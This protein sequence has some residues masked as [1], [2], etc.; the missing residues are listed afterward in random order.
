MVAADIGVTL[1]I[2]WFKCAR[3]AALV[4]DFLTAVRRC[5]FP[6]VER[7]KL[8]YDKT[9]SAKRIHILEKNWRLKIA[10]RSR[11]ILVVTPAI[12][13]FACNAPVTINRTVATLSQSQLSSFQPRSL[14][15]YS[16]TAAALQA[17]KL[18]IASAISLANVNFKIPVC[19][20][21]A[22]SFSRLSVSEFF[23]RSLSF[24]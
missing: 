22:V 8:S 15:G 10:G 11:T 16:R 23:F 14:V 6:R 24:K 5:Y 21:V 3:A 19:A 7:G 12:F 2:S 13:F 17:R 18:L 1:G 4:I 20:I 9:L